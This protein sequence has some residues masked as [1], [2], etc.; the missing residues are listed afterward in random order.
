MR[1][2]RFPIAALWQPAPPVAREVDGW[3][4]ALDLGVPAKP[5]SSTGRSRRRSEPPRVDAAPGDA[6]RRAGAASRAPKPEWDARPVAIVEGQRITTV[7]AAGAAK[8]LRAGMTVAEARAR[9]ADLTLVPHDWAA[10]TDAILRVTAALVGASPQVTP[11]SGAPGTWWVGASGFDAVGGEAALADAL[12]A[13]AR[14]WHPE[15]RVAI[16]DACVVARAATWGDATDA[17]RRGVAT[18]SASGGVVVH[19]QAGAAYLAPAPLALVPMDAEVREGL[20]AL[21]LE[22]AGAF[23]ALD[24]GDVEARWGLEGLAAWRLVHGVDARRPSLVR[25]DRPGAVAAELP[26]PAATLEPVLFLVRAALERLVAGLVTDARAAAVVAITLT[27]D[28]ARGALPER[29][30]A[31]TVTREVR[32]PAPL[33]RVAPLFERCR[34][35]L[36]T[37]TLPAP[38]T[39]VE[40][41]VTATAP[42]GGEQGGLLDSAWRDPAAA[43]AALERLRAE[44]GTQAVVRPALRDTHRPEGAGVWEDVAVA[45]VAARAT[46]GA[47]AAP[48]LDDGFAPEPAPAEGD[49]LG[50]LRLLAPAA[51]VEVEV[52]RTA[53]EER[54]RALW[55]AGRRVALARV[56]GPERLGGDWWSSPWQRDYWRGEG[57]LD[58]DAPADLVLFRDRQGPERGWYLHGW[59]D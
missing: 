46:P 52:E 33:A 20:V 49:M 9:C 57:A 28:D 26:V 59:V 24:A 56:Q 51:R 3:Q 34:A 10:L 23:A 48:S 41:A 18:R 38:V 32:C 25:S 44:L 1:I 4:L 47:E 36:D 35:L 16:A 15:A 29:R 43:D 45:G 58:G 8:R 40:V 13:I 22:T 2:P 12:L 6:A 50:A 19:A 39:A 27:L 55:W 7:S 21:G 5:G 14:A 31:H 54:P 53:G 30:R 11:A 17:V 42:M 37:W